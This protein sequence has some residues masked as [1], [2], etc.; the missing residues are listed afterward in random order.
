MKNQSISVKEFSIFLL[1][2]AI[3]LWIIVP[4]LPEGMRLGYFITFIVSFPLF[5]FVFSRWM[6]KKAHKG[7]GKFEQ[8]VIKNSNKVTDEYQA[9][10]VEYQKK[11][12]FIKQSQLWSI[13]CLFLGCFI[14]WGNFSHNPPLYEPRFFSI[15]VFSLAFLASINN[16]E[17]EYGIDHQIADCIIRGANIEQE[18]SLKT[19]PMM[20]AKV[21]YEGK[22]IYLFSLVRLFP[23][24]MIIAVLLQTGVAPLLKSYRLGFL[25]YI[26]FAGILGL[27]IAFLGKFLFPPYRKIRCSHK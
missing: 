3:F 26:L 6:N 11:I 24:L 15:A 19:T 25:Q 2:G 21:R 16:I 12:R 5:L 9:L 27:V 14:A 8:D 23:R 4:R 1:I 18:I 22:S 13:A 20:K 10:L 17:K 7:Q